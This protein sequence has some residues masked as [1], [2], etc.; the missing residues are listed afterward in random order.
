MTSSEPVQAEE[1]WVN[2][3]PFACHRVGS[4][5]RNAVLVHGFPDDPSTMHQLMRRLADDDFTCW[6]PFLRG[7]AP[8][9]PPP[10][11]DYS[12]RA[13]AEDLNGLIRSLS[14]DAP[15]HLVGHDW[16]ALIGYAAAA[17][18]PGPIRRFVAMSVSP[19]LTMTRTML[20]HPRQL[21]RGAYILGFQLPMVPERL[22]RR[23]NQAFI[24]A[25]WRR[26]SPGWAPPPAHLER[27]K[28]TLRTGATL[29]NA[30]S[31]YRALLRAGASQ[32]LPWLRS[33]ALHATSEIQVRT[34]IIAGESDGCA[35]PECYDAVASAFAEPP[36]LA[37]L[38][39]CGHFPHL[40]RPEDVGDR[41]AD[42]FS[43]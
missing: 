3:A 31:Y 32:P 36:Q 30:M 35:G 17:L 21:L 22:L 10:G 1:V 12:L 37:L 42:F 41:I 15:V 13:L 2:G 18:D 28:R 7:Y 4:G 33:V 43:A 27:V 24:D 26:W 6:A 5:R 23:R 19:T 9:A 8:S 40:E 38:P 25:I 16:G 29:S 34:L 39:D 20:R 11:N 14:P